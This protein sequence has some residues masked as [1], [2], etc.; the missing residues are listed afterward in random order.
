[1]EDSGGKETYMGENEKCKQS[2]VVKSEENR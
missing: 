1:M 2:L